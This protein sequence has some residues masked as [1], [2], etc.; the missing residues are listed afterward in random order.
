MGLLLVSIILTK[1]VGWEKQ[2]T[3]KCMHE[4][5]KRNYWTEPTYFVLI[6]EVYILSDDKIQ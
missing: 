2:E 3:G 5:N 6:P 4:M 1:K